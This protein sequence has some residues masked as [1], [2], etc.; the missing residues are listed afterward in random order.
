MK[1][2]V[3]GLGY[4]GTVAAAGLAGAG[5][6]VLG[7]DI[8]QRRID[9]LGAGCVPMYEPGLESQG[10]VRSAKSVRSDSGIETRFRKTSAMLR[11]SRRARLPRMAAPRICSR[12][13]RR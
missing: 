9:M 4:V 1:I 8:D 5:H 10:V 2:T 3:V 6:D 11:S 13:G 12:S 7:I